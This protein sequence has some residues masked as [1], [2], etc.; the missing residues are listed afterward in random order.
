MLAW[1]FSLKVE[2][3]MFLT[4]KKIDNLLKYICD[5]KFEI[6]RAYLVGIL[7]HLNKLDLQ[8]YKALQVYIHI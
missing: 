8:L 5:H 2:V 7:E 4:E 1:L 6:H 3:V